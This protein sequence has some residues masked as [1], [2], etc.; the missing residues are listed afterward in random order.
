MAASHLDAAF[1]DAVPLDLDVV[2]RNRE[3]W[4]AIGQLLHTGIQAPATSSV[5]RLF[6]A[7]ASLVGLRDRVS[8]ACQAAI[9]LELRADRTE[10]GHDPLPL[11]EGASEGGRQGALL[12]LDAAELIRAVVADLTDGA[13]ASRIAGRLHN[14]LARA[15]VALCDAVRERRGLDVVALSGGVF[16][17]QLLLERTTAG[18]SDAGFRVLT[19]A[20]LPPNDGGLSYGQAVVAA[21]R[22]RLRN[23]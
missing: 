9:L 6:D 16:Q 12:E 11:R 14:S 21:A 7:V 20:A 13:P 15:T 2:R 5:G 23:P 18:L 19:H 1:G 4:D 10:G 8:F 22:A 3:R 17:N